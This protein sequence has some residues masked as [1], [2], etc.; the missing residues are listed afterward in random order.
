MPQ[1]KEFMRENVA[2]S[3]NCKWYIITEVMVRDEAAEA[4]GGVERA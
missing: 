3:R 2:C 1:A 4:G